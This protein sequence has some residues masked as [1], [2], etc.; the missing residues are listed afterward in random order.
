MM[1]V[2][3]SESAKDTETKIKD[4]NIPPD[5]K[6]QRQTAVSV[7]SGGQRDVNVGDKTV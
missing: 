3:V 2:R 1:W 4:I 6:Q 5:I 7:S